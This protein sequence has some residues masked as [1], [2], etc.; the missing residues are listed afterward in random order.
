MMWSLDVSY[1]LQFV[2]V[3]CRSAPT[4]YSPTLV[5]SC[6]VILHCSYFNFF[7]QVALSK[8]DTIS[9]DTNI[10][11]YIFYKYEDKVDASVSM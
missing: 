9:E 8:Q 1:A 10:H 2:P 5:H 3:S 11:T 6:S 4:L 7:L